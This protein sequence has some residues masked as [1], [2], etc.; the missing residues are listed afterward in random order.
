MK[1]NVLLTE[2]SSCWSVPFHP[3]PQLFIVKILQG[4][5]FRWER[6]QLI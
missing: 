1:Q 2:K 4:K 6:L 3:L 5:F